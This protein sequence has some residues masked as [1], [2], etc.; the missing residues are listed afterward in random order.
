MRK[1]PMKNYFILFF[2]GLITVSIVLISANLYKK[3]NK[4]EYSSVMSK[5]VTEITSYDFENYLLENPSAVVYISSKTDRKLESFEMELKQEL[6]NY[7]IQ[8]YFVYLDYNNISYSL[9]D[10]LKNNYN[11]NVTV[12][13]LPIF[14]IIVDG[15]VVDTLY[16]DNYLISEIVE[17]LYT[18]EVIE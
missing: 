14:I 9:L 15:K 13:K 7:N 12:D 6:A 18:N 16:E 17:I 8:K 5:F 10:N 11:I 1:I 2:I 4:D 3:T